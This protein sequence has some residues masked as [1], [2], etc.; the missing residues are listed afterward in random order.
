MLL[1]PL[2]VCCLFSA[3]IVHFASYRSIPSSPKVPEI[4]RLGLAK[5]FVAYSRSQLRISAITHVDLQKIT[6]C[7]IS[8]DTLPDTTWNLCVWCWKTQCHLVVSIFVDIARRMFRVCSRFS[9]NVSENLS[10]QLLFGNR[11]CVYPEFWLEC[12]Q[13]IIGLPLLC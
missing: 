3:V 6:Y 11:V 12:Q 1:A 9:R 10:A 13:P 8:A 4:V 5:L 2:S 7:L